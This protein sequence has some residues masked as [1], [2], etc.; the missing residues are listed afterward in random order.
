MLNK[1]WWHAEECNYNFLKLWNFLRWYEQNEGDIETSPSLKTKIWVFSG[2]LRLFIW[3]QNL[4]WFS[5]FLK[6]MI[7]FSFSTRCIEYKESTLAH[8]RN[9]LRMIEEAQNSE[10]REE[11]HARLER[12]PN[13][14][15]HAPSHCSLQRA[16][17]VHTYKLSLCTCLCLIGRN[18]IIIFWAICLVNWLWWFNLFN[19]R[20]D[21]WGKLQISGGLRLI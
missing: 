20:R 6:N 8:T 1:G 4:L 12:A 3:N 16:G 15:S 10:K 21:W 14:G 17:R 2:F 7:K 13:Q 11:G 18:L 19:H 9:W 5:R